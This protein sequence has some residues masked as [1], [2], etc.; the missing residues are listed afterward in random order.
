MKLRK[1][2]TKDWVHVSPGLVSGG[3]G[4]GGVWECVEIGYNF[5]GE[6]CCEVQMRKNGVTNIPGN[7][8]KQ[9]LIHKL[10]HLIRE[11][12]EK[13]GVYFFSLELNQYI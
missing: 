3:A 4:E 10:Q 11:I 2:V 1:L 7:V 12:Y 9:I 13:R 6:C 8:V 5:F